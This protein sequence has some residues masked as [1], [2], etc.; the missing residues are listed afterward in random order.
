M[1]CDIRG[2][3]CPLAFVKAKHAL[4]KNDVK[5]FLFDDDISLNNFCQY[6]KNKDILYKQTENNENPFTQLTI[7]ST[8]IN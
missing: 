6:L 1:E 3:K 8:F 7:Q 2:I 4:I 5:I